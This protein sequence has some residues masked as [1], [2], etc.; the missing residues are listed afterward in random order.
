MALGARRVAQAAAAQAAHDGSIVS[1][2]VARHAVDVTRA[3]MPAASVMMNSSPLAQPSTFPTPPSSDF[4]SSNSN[5]TDGMSEERLATPPQVEVT[6]EVTDDSKH[7]YPNSKLEKT[8]Q[9]QTKQQEL[10][11]NTQ[12]SR[13]P[14]ERQAQST[15]NVPTSQLQQTPAETTQQPQPERLVEGRRVPSTRVGRAMGFASL[16]AGLAWGTV[17]ELASRVVGTADKKTTS[18]VASSANA[19]RLAET[20]CRMRGAALKLGQMLSIQDS[21]SV[22]DPTLQQAL[23]QVRQG[24]FA[25]PSSQLNQQLESQLGQD[26]RKRYNVVEFDEHPFAA[27]SIGQV[28]RAKVQMDDNSIKNVVVKVQYPGVATSI[29]SDLRNLQMLVTMTGLAPKGLYMEE[30]IRVGRQELH[31]ECD[32][33]RESQN[34]EQ[35]RQLVEQDDYLRKE[36]VQVPRVHPHLSTSQILTS[37]HA[38]GSTIDQVSLLPQEER[39][40]IA[41]AILYLTLQELFV[42]RFMQ[43]D[44]NWGNF[45]YDTHTATT[46]LIDFGAT[47]EYPKTFVDGYLRIVCANANRNV[48]ILMQKSHEMGF[49]TGEENDIM[50]EAHIQSGFIV[51]EPFA[52]EDPYDFGASQ[53]SSRLSEQSAAFLEHRLTPPPEEV[54]TLHRKLAGAY[55]LCIKLGAKVSCRDMLRQVVQ[56]H[57]F[58][59]GEEPPVV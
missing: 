28:H 43:T 50:N 46:Y 5:G 51:G 6:V 55:M 36:R 29:E 26:W 56:N 47:R 3:A 14:Q 35:F 11:L 41:R 4:T 8:Q 20:L 9:Q 33:V 19:Q 13:N 21:I 16:G 42:W 7:S 32:Y 40:R 1:T 39:N 52:S 38:P 27:A 48:D 58:E 22:L 53:L 37:D 23:E 2:C 10:A 31:V 17:T 44:P 25:M 15:N 49:L 34:Q 24:A 45:L 57:A 59:D 12:T 54:Y 30:I 18:A